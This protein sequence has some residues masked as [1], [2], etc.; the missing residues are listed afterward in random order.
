M[1]GSDQEARTPGGLR[2]GRLPLLRNEV[3][4]AS[5]ATTTLVYPLGKAAD[6]FAAVDMPWSVSFCRPCPVAAT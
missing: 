4:G 2:D 3:A 5:P 6:H 1:V